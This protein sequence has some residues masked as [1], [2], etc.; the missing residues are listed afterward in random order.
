MINHLNYDRSI[1]KEYNNVMKAKTLQRYNRYKLCNSNLFINK[2]VFIAYIDGGISSCNPIDFKNKFTK[3]STKETNNSIIDND[4]VLRIQHN[5]FTK[6][7]VTTPKAISLINEYL[8]NLPKEYNGIHIRTFGYFNDFDE[9]AEDRK[10][11]ISVIEKNFIDSIKMT[12]TTNYYIASDSIKMKR[13]LEE[14]GIKNNVSIFYSNDNVTHSRENKRI[15]DRNIFYE[16]EVMSLSYELLLTN[17]STFSMLIFFKNKNC[18]I[19][20]KCLFMTFYTRS[21]NGYNKFLRRFYI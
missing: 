1:E 11:N 4:Y 7:F 3:L 21:G 17:L 18:F 15:L 20:N 10:I 2:D 13:Y 19:F 8:D 6:Y 9:N 14:L 16:L 12:T 5:I